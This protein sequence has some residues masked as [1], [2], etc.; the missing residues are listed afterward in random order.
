MFNY[1]NQQYLKEDQYKDSSNLNARLAIH[2][3]YSVNPYGF[4]KWI[5]DRV[6][7]LPPNAKILELGCGPADMW[8]EA[9]DRIPAGWAITL[10]DLSPGMLDSAWR[11]LVVTGRSYQFKE[12]DAQSIPFE[13]ETFDAVIANFMLY[14]VPDRPKAFAEIKRVLKPGGHFI[15]A[16]IGDNHMK[17]MIEKLKRVD[18]KQEEF[19]NPF[20]LESGLDQVTPFFSNVTLT[21]YEDA[22]RVTAIEPIEAYIRSSM[23]AVEISQEGLAEV[24]AELEK[25]I[26]EKGSFFIT[27]DV[28][29]FEAVK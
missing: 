14:H 17:E 7:K 23:R 11:N 20:T 4:H 15:A 19:Q 24:R 21:R 28:G 3:Y 1:T 29:L 5:F 22:L 8:V 6:L 9:Q 25:E 10:S 13:D 2:K 18:A 16:T 26:K 27:K 12:I